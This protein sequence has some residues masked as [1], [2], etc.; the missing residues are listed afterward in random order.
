M[1]EEAVNVNCLEL[2]PMA[3]VTMAVRRFVTVMARDRGLARLA[4]QVLQECE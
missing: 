3:T 4:T 2:A 1:A